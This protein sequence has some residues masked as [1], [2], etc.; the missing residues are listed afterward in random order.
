M[1]CGD[2]NALADSAVYELLST[3]QI[4][5]NHPGLRYDPCN[6]LPPAQQLR[7][8]LMLQSAHVQCLGAEPPFT[9]YTTDFSGCIDY[10][11]LSCESVAVSACYTIPT[12]EEIRELSDAALPHPQY[13]SDHFALCFDLKFLGRK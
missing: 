13:P 10:I 3:E 6:I 7:H 8:G 11:W 2:F 4:R 12:E 9:N 5:P 1:L